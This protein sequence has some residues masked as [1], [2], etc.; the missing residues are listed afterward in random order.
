MSTIMA[1]ATGV[2]FGFFVGIM[3]ASYVNEYYDRKEK[4]EKEDKAFAIT[5]ANYEAKERK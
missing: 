1:V 3:V 4:M 2:M 5:K